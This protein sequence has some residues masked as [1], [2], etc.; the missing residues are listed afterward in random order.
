MVYKYHLADDLTVPNYAKGLLFSQN[1]IH[2]A[3]NTTGGLADLEQA[4][5]QDQIAQKDLN[6][7][8]NQCKTVKFTDQELNQ[9]LPKIKVG[10]EDFGRYV[11]YGRAPFKT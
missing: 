4:K 8:Y 9:E 11:G 1:T 2:N 3:Q 5:F 6:L 7:T 10:N